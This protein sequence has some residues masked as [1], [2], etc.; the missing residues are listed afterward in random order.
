MVKSTKR[1]RKKNSRKKKSN[2]GKL[3]FDIKKNIVMISSSLLLFLLAI[4]VFKCN[5][6]EEEKPYKTVEDKEFYK[7]NPLSNVLKKTI[8]PEKKLH[9]L[10]M[11]ARVKRFGVSGKTKK[12][13]L[14]GMILRSLRFSNITDKVEKRYDLPKYII[15]AMVMQETGGAD[16]VPNSSDDGG[17]GLCHMQPSVAQMFGLK[18]YKNCKKLVC[19]KHGKELRKKIEEYNYDRHKLIELDERFDPVLN[20]D[21]VGRI[22]AYHRDRKQKGYTAIQRAIRGYSGRYNYSKYYKNV[23]YFRQKLTDEDVVDEVRKEFNRRN[24]N[25]LIGNIKADFDAYLKYHHDQNRNY[26]L[27]EYPIEIKN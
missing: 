5:S 12:E 21:A 6:N 9:N 8:N 15:L 27:D 25:L 20:L 7:I 19:K 2:F 24:T 26:G 22:L 16:F 3:R 14:M 4:V 10:Q 11:I 23:M 1:K 13:R 17:F 18:T